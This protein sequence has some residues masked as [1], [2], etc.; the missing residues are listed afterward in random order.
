LTFPIK[1]AAYTITLVLCHVLSILQLS[2][3]DT[4]QCGRRV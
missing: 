3:Y 2:T 4:I 1:S